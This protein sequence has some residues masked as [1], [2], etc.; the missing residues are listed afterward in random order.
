LRNTLSDFM[1]E[2]A[3]NLREYTE[4][5]AGSGVRFFTT[6][7]AVDHLNAGPVAVRAQIRRL[8]EKGAIATPMKSFHLIIPPEY[9]RLGCLPA[10][11]FIDPLMRRLAQPYYVGLLSA[12]ERH[13]AAHQRPQAFQ[14]MTSV[15]RR[16]IECG[17][18]R[19]EF[20]ARRHIQRVPNATISAPTGYVQYST[21]EATALDLVGYPNHAGGLGNVA[22]VLSELADAIDA[23][24]LVIAASVSPLAWSQRLGYLLD[25]LG[26]F[27]RTAPLADFVAVR[28]RSDA[29]LRRARK[30]APSIRHAKWKLLV[31]TDVE[32]DE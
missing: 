2:S 12:A 10:E 24:K 25:R 3:K 17:R 22:T 28:A 26:H 14:V 11:Q 23:E 29:L 18:V 19:I 27:S 7:E 20:I 5:L 4:N 13:G 15:N 32:P 8:R 9:R 30:G 31:N 16:P 1:Q 6:D 21:P